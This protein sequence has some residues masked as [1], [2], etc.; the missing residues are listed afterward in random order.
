MSDEIS[1]KE[2]TNKANSLSCSDKQIRKRLFYVINGMDMH[3]R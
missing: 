3:T 2:I 1:Y